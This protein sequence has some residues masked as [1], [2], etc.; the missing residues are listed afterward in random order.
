MAFIF[1]I[2]IY[3]HFYNLFLSIIFFFWWGGGEGGVGKRGVSNQN[4]M[5]D[6]QMS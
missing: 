4:S 5:R 2:Y 6:C 3:I 1:Y